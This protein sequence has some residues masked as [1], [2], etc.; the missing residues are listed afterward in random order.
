MPDRFG[1][2]R[3]V[4]IGSPANVLVFP[5]KEFLHS[6]ALLKKNLREKSVYRSKV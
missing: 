2:L 5:N 3:I 6:E 1:R 4:V